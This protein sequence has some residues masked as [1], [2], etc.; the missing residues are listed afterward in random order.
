MEEIGYRTAVFSLKGVTGSQREYIEWMLATCAADKV[1]VD[2]ILNPAAVDLLASRLRT[3][4]QI[5]QHLTL[6]LETGYKASEKPVGEAWTPLPRDSKVVRSATRRMA[7]GIR[8]QRG[9]EGSTARRRSAG[10]APGGTR[11]HDCW[12]MNSRCA[13]SRLRQGGHSRYGAKTPCP[14]RAHAPGYVRWPAPAPTDFRVVEDLQPALPR[15]VA[16]DLCHGCEVVAAV[17]RQDVVAVLHERVRATA[18]LRWTGAVAGG[19]DGI[20]LA[21]LRNPPV[22]DA[23]LMPPGNV[24]VVLID[25]PRAPCAAAGLLASRQATRP[26]TP[27]SH[28]ARHEGR[29]G[30]GEGLPIPSRPG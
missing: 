27:R 7:A 23:D 10:A 1:K 17:Q 16:D 5:E 11:H 12:C 3:P 9:D 14:E 6:A 15:D 20:G 18:V 22:L 24:Q 28:S 8:R 13:P 25:E 21:C 26:T 29:T 19:T 30:K 4:L 2:A